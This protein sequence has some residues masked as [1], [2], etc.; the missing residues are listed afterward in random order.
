MEVSDEFFRW[1]GQHKADDVLGLR[2]KYAGRVSPE[3]DYGFAITQ[4]ECRK[5][6]GKK[7][8]ACLEAFPG[9]LFPSV[10][11]GEQ[12]TSALLAEY[13]DSLIGPGATVADLTAGLGMDVF[14]MAARAK[15][16]TAVELDTERA[17]VLRYN[18]AGLQHHN[19]TVIEGD[20]R[21]YID[22]CCDRGIVY[23]VIFIDPARRAD[24]GSRI[25]AI[26]DCQPDIR[27]M[28]PVL[29]KVCRRL[30]VKAS[31]MLDV[32]HIMEALPLRPSR[33]ILLG[34]QTE[35]KE[36]I[37]DV[38]MDA[39][40]DG[41]TLISAVTLRGDGSVNS[42]DFFRSG[43]AAMPSPLYAGKIVVGN[44]VYEP[45]PSLMKAGAFKL[46]ATRSGLDIIAPNTHLYCGPKLVEFHGMCYKV[47]AVYPFAS[48]VIKRFKGL[49]PR[50][51]VAVRNFG[52]SADALRSRLGV[53]DGG[54]LRL[55]GFTDS[56]GER[57]LAVVSKA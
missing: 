10:L 55:Y 53:S 36:L 2:L 49:Y 3:I 54:V 50:I 17:A 28:F 11:A 15:A 38:R 26:G 31:P 35:C 24:D 34:T 8:G 4:I 23:D 12:S 25:F 51:N 1:V 20:C 19:V 40:P 45:Y 9:F 16:V 5:R 39:V 32:A 52:I 48:K 18:A 57:M 7:I 42:F 27:E 22:C 30:I 6:F 21:D 37:L 41:E 29:S 43:E 13:H 33:V 44:Y 47:E 46:M 14:A 56:C